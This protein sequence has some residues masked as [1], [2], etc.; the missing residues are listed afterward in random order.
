[1]FVILKFILF[2]NE[3]GIKARKKTTNWIKE[4]KKKR[5]LHK[6]EQRPSIIF[7]K[8]SKVNTNVNTE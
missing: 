4:E 5:L 6:F 1:M 3:Q 7:A 8:F 2:K